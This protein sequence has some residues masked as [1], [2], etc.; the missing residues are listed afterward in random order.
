MQGDKDSGGDRYPA[1]PRPMADGPGLD[2]AATVELIEAMTGM[3]IKA[4]GIARDGLAGGDGLAV[5]R[6]EILDRMD[7]HIG[8]LSEPVRLAIEDHVK[9]VVRAVLDD[10]VGES[11]A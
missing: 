9:R 11:E 2:E 10:H 4:L 1:R 6:G 5:I 7:P 8:E 3:T